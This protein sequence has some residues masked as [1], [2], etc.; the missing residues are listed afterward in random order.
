[1]Q[2]LHVINFL[3]CK[4]AA[5]E[6]GWFEAMTIDRNRTHPARP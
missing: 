5:E 1:M 3:P 4:E 6:M 2:R